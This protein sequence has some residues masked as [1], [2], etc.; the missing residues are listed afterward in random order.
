MKFGYKSREKERIYDRQNEF[1]MTTSGYGRD[2]LITLLGIGHLVSNPSKFPF[3]G[4]NDSN[5]QNNKFFNGKYSFGAVADLDL[6][7]K[8]Y[9][10]YPRKL[11]YRRSTR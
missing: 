5:Y 7:M 10:F 6:M 2:S 1:L 3:L 9:K 8:I 4:F 11:G